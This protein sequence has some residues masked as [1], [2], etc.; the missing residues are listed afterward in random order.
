M[1]YLLLMVNEYLLG[2]I[3]TQPFKARIMSWYHLSPEGTV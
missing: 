3:G 1:I 2:S